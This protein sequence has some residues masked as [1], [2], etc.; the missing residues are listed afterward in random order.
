MMASYSSA[1][2][3]STLD[4]GRLKEVLKAAIV[5]VFEER[6][7]LVLGLIEEALED[8]ALARAMEEGEGSPLVSRE[9]VFKILDEP[10]D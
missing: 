3:G 4:E 8:V 1:M 9:D 2:A 5:E 7:D 6:R 10:I